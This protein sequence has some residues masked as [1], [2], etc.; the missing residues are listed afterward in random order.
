MSLY[1]TVTFFEIV[2]GDWGFDLA[3]LEFKVFSSLVVDPLP[4]SALTIGGYSTLNKSSQYK[5][6][7]HSTD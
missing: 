1:S 2:I 4:S 3:P 6:W 7:L 5:K